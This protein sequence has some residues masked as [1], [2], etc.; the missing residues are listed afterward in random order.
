MP[1]GTLHVA[2]CERRFERTVSST[3]SERA[4]TIIQ[5]YVTDILERAMTR[6]QLYVTDFLAR[7]TGYERLAFATGYE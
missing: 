1:I 2:Q 6:V 4:M 7:A 3:R 5:L